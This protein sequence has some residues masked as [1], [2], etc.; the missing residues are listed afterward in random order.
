MV[1]SRYILAGYQMKRHLQW[2]ASLHGFFAKSP[3]GFRPPL[4]FCLVAGMDCAW[5]GSSPVLPEKWLHDWA[6]LPVM[7]QTSFTCISYV[8]GDLIKDSLLLG[9]HKGD[10]DALNLGM[11]FRTG[12][13][14]P[15]DSMVCRCCQQFC[16][17]C[18]HMHFD[19]GPSDM[20]QSVLGA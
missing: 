19:T 18:G 6:W 10:S 16:S 1:I 8:F 12:L 14:V 17:P 11:L 4:S 5:V 2:T 13:Q 20:D 7:I 3:S 15:R 9:E